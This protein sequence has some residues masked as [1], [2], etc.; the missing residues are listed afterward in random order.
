MR[1]RDRAAAGRT[2]VE[3]LRRYRSAPDTLVLAVPRGGVPI[4]AVIA[5]ELH[6]PLDVILVHKLRHPR[7][8]EL[9]V[10]AVDEAGEVLLG[11]AARGIDAE[12]LDAE[13]QHQLAVLHS[14]RAAIA[15][16][17]P[18]VALE[19]RTAILVDDGAATG[20]TL[21][22]AVALLRRRGVRR[23]VVAV[24][25]ASHDALRALQTAAD[26]VVCL[27]GPQRFGAVGRHYDRFDQV[28]D[29]QVRA[30]LARR[31]SPDQPREVEV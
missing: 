6:L 10:G 25:V 1:F 3:S 17:R 21:L 29:R 20:S 11:D 30:A 2:L 9:A 28:E 26:E 31:R 19:G 5:E 24:P 7:A 18:P 8:P 23:V 16:V 22:A 14:R 4:G 13:V 12:H 27:Y 15:D